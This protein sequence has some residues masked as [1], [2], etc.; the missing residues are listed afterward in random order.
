MSPATWSWIAAAVSVVGL[1]ISGQNPR[2]GWAFGI[3]CQAIWVT[4]GLSTSQPGMI[5]LSVAFVA[6]YS[7]NLWRWRGTRFERAGQTPAPVVA[8]EQAV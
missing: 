1:W 6:L 3:A 5:A 8:T 4:Y 2:A 7:R